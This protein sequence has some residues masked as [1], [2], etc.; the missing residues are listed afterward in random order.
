MMT[1]VIVATAI[2]GII[3]VGLTASMSAFSS[4]NDYQWARQRCIAAAQAQLDSITATGR[5]VEPQE[6]TRLWGTVEVSVSREPG[7][8]QW[9]GLELIRVTAAGQAGPRPVTVHLA[10]YIRPNVAVAKGE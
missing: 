4:F 2:L 7:A 6:L 9:E 10:R 8:A 3:I 1:E 5:P